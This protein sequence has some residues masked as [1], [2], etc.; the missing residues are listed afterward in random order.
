MTGLL[1]WLPSPKAEDVEALR[2]NDDD[3]PPDLSFLRR[4]SK[5]EWNN[6]DLRR[7]AIRFR[8]FVHTGS[9]EKDLKASNFQAARL[10]VFSNTTANHLGEVI[11]GTGIRH[12]LHI[13]T[14]I[15]EYEEPEAYLERNAAEVADFAPDI[16]LIH[17]DINGF[18]LDEALSANPNAAENIADDAHQRLAAIRA[19]IADKISVPVIY[20]TVTKNPKASLYSSD[21]IMYGS[22][23]NCVDTFN[24][25]LAEAVRNS[26]DSLLDVASLAESVGLNNWFSARYWALAKYPFSPDYAPYFAEHLCRLI[27]MRLGKSKRVLV[28]D[29][30]NTVWGGIVGDDGKENLEIGAGSPVGAS[31]SEIQ[32]MAKS[33]TKRGII[34]ALSSKNEE[35]I[36]LDAIQN[37]PEMILKLEDIAAYQINWTDKAQNI[38]ALSK[39]LNLGLDSFVFLDDNPAERKRVREAL[40]D[41]AVPEVPKDVSEWLCVFQQARY[42]ESG[43]FSEED[44]KR[45]EMYR[46]NAKRA[47]A[48]AA[49]EDHDAY[50]KSLEMKLD[51]RAFDKMGRKR[52]AQLISKSNQFNLTTKRRS[53]EELARLEDDLNISTF[54]LRLTDKV[55]DNGMIAVVIAEQT[56]RYLNIDTWLM[57]CRVLGR[58]VEKTTLN[59]LVEHAKTKGISEIQGSYLPTP[60]N[61]IVKNHF[62]D[63]GFSKISEDDDGATHWSL[64]VKAYKP[65]NT[66]IEIVGNYKLNNQPRELVK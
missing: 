37:H 27:A 6:S 66:P 32:S 44:A 26:G 49:F 9:G 43:G 34:L 29:L 4:L 8:E 51:A 47:S 40:L 59:L 33:L 41:V 7:L 19:A 20:Q 2:K 60:K 22:P 55:G 16:V 24:T 58:G 64:D 15:V 17:F 35:D 45:S 38:V 3:Y 54:Q 18:N 52:I 46:A 31:H 10:L 30:D 36:A 28:L 53:E 48:A 23:K 39:S 25:K 65:S 21:F 50:L 13:E 61:K 1:P 42:F 56:D 14:L 12:G 62:E 57:S 5:L 63:L 11:T